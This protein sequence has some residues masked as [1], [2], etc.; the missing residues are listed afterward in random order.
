MDLPRDVPL[1]ANVDDAF[2]GNLLL[3]TLSADQ[4]AELESAEAKKAR[5]DEEAALAELGSG[6]MDMDSDDE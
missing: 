5:E 1:E 4:R 2:A 3:A 6:D